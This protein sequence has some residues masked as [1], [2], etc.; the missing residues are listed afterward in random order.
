MQLK[1]YIKQTILATTFIF[2]IQIVF[3]SF[4]FTGNKNGQENS[5][6]YSLKYYSSLSNKR[7]F[8]KNN[9]FLLRIKLSELN[10]SPSMLRNNNYLEITKGNSTIIYPYKLK[11]KVPKFKTPT[12]PT[13]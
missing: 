13:N 7:L 4:T 1:K 12:A 3:A 6:K 9:K 8:Y 5:K 11:V 2:A 10:M